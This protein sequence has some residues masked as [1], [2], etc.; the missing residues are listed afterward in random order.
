MVKKICQQMNE[1]ILLNDTYIS[2]HNRGTPHFHS[3]Y[4]LSKGT[5]KD[6]PNG[7]KLMPK[8]TYLHF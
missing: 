4:R 5:Q 6:T 1:L 8:G 2:V 7:I 3:W